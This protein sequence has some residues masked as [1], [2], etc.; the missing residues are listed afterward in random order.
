MEGE[1]TK[2]PPTV[3]GWYWWRSGLHEGTQPRVVQLSEYGGRFIAAA[4]GAA[5]RLLTSLSGEWWSV[6]IQQPPGA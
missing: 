2:T 4:C 3:P 5:F 1:W 6:P